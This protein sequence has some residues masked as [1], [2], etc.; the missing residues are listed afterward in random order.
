MKVYD[1]VPHRID[2]NLIEAIHN[3]TTTLDVVE[4][5]IGNVLRDFI[6]TYPALTTNWTEGVTLE[7]VEIIDGHSDGL[8]YQ[9]D[10][11]VVATVLYMSDGNHSVDF[12]LQG[13]NFE[14]RSG[15]FLAFPAFW[16]HPY[17]VMGEGRYLRFQIKR[18]ST[19][20]SECKLSST[21]AFGGNSLLTI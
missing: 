11:D 14:G 12:P 8:T 18:I 3:T 5:A 20:W 2:C 10:T 17:Q 9:G 6:K 16:T 1:G 4:N 13:I 19:P 21:P 7:S 15:R